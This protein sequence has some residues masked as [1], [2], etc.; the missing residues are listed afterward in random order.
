MRFLGIGLLL[1]I[2]LGTIL[3]EGEVFLVDQLLDA[4]H[5]VL[6]LL[7]LTLEL[8]VDLDHILDQQQT[9]H[10]A[11]IDQP[12]G[13]GAYNGDGDAVHTVPL[14]VAVV[15]ATVAGEAEQHTHTETDAAD[16]GQHIEEPQ[17]LFDDEELEG[18]YIVQ[19]LS[20]LVKVVSLLFGD[21]VDVG[22]HSQNHSSDQGHNGHKSDSVHGYLSF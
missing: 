19:E 16:G 11:L 10:A 9:H 20:Q 12:Q 17:D 6:L 5:L 4:G 2:L 15:V 13:N 3:A 8:A 14:G 1:G 22:Q 21:N 7:D 18:E